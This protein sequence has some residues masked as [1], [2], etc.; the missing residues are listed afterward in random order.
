MPKAQKQG[1]GRYMHRITGHI[2]VRGERKPYLELWIKI[3]PE[4]WK[5]LDSQIQKLT[6]KSLR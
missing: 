1:H 3:A 2:E 6:K 4:N 5:K